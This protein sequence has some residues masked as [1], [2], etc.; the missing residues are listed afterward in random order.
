MS[1][2]TKISLTAIFVLFSKNHTKKNLQNKKKYCGYQ[3]H[4]W[5][6]W[7]VFMT[8]YT[9]VLNRFCFFPVMYKPWVTR[10]LQIAFFPGKKRCQMGGIYPTLPISKREAINDKKSLVIRLPDITTTVKR[11]LGGTSNHK[12]MQISDHFRHNWL[13]C[14]PEA[15]IS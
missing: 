3:W 6:Q 15:I 7:H 5:F 12:T 1:K 11:L 13:T 4:R 14:Y 2:Q 10:C 8:F 9:L